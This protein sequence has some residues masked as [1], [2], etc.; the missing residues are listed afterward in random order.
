MSARV[1]SA[2]LFLELPGSQQAGSRQAGCVGDATADLSK[3]RTLQWLGLPT[4][5]ALVPER[6]V[7]LSTDRRRIRVFIRSN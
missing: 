4:A 5:L 7:I 1:D 6:I 2:R 3:N